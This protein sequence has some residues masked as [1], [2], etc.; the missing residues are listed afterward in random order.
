MEPKHHRLLLLIAML[1][2]FVGVVFSYDKGN[3]I[4]LLLNA[5]VLF[6]LLFRWMGTYK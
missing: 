6:L 3:D 1:V 4:G 5:G 2:C